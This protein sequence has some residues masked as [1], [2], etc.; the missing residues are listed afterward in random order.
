MCPSMCFVVLLCWA[1]LWFHTSLCCLSFSSFIFP[2]VSPCFILCFFLWHLSLSR[3]ISS[4][5]CKLKASGQV[6]VH[7]PGQLSLLLRKT[8]TSLCSV[9]W[10]YHLKPVHLSRH[11][12]AYTC[13]QV[14]YLI[15]KA[16]SLDFSDFL[17][18]TKLTCLFWS[19]D[20]LVIYYHLNLNVTKPVV[21]HFYYK[22][23]L[24]NMTWNSFCPAAIWKLSVWI[25]Q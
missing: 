15:L 6:T 22:G 14:I 25:K 12:L 9:S 20:S 7:K 8:L 2:V 1:P 23:D 19:L 17:E 5:P 24:F 18:T 3:T 11:R 10:Y 21:F 16:F 4:F 13:Q